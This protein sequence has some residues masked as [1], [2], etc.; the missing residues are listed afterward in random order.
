MLEWKKNHGSISQVFFDNDFAFRQSYSSKRFDVYYLFADANTV[1]ARTRPKEDWLWVHTSRIPNPPPGEII[2][3]RHNGRAS[4]VKRIIRNSGPI[5]T[6]EL[7]LT[8]GCC[9]KKL[10]GERILYFACF[11][12]PSSSPSCAHFSLFQYPTFPG[13]LLF[14]SGI[15]SRDSH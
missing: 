2:S 10:E 1:H 11:G 15:Y 14:G 4:P 13:H 3:F 6:S 7:P 9:S 12:P 8:M 5:V